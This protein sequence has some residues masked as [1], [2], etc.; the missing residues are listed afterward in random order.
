ME[1][2]ALENRN[3]GK[4]TATPRSGELLEM[5]WSEHRLSNQ[6]FEIR[7]TR[8]PNTKTRFRKQRVISKYDEQ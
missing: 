6:H 7:N 2:R 8:K 4:P 5:I 1:K 3:T